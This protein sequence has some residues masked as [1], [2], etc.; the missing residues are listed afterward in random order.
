MID[1]NF[2]ALIAE[3]ET[4]GMRVEEIAVKTGASAS[5][6]YKWKRGSKPMMIYAERVEA[7]LTRERRKA[8]A[9]N[10]PKNGEEW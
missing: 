5:S 4:L 3:L 9:L 1:Q 6:V 7:L 2:P 10:A 8:S